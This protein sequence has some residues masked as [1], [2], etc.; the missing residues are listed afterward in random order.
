MKHQLP[1]ESNPSECRC[2]ARGTHSRL[3]HREKRADQAR[4]VGEN[5]EDPFWLGPVPFLAG[6]GQARV[7][8]CCARSNQGV[9]RLQ[10][11]G[12]SNHSERLWSGETGNVRTGESHNPP[13]ENVQPVFAIP[14]N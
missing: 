7:K 4:V 1:G 9:V 12:A 14:A 10:L 3:R 13:A 5:W 8:L 11:P 2:R 6:A